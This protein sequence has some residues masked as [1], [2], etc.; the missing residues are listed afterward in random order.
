MG[1]LDTAERFN[2]EGVCVLLLEQSEHTLEILLQM[3]YG[4]GARNCHKC[5]TIGEAKYVAERHTLDLVVLDP[6]L[7]EGDGLDFLRWLR[8]S[9][10]LANRSTPVLVASANG[11]V[12]SVR[13]ARDAG[14]NF[15]IVKP[16]TPAVLMDRIV[17]VTRD[18]RSF[19]VSDVYQGPDR[20]FKMEG[21]PPGL[22]PRRSTDITTRLGD[23]TEPN[24][25]QDDINSLFKPQK[26]ML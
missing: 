23:A 13:G 8:A 19:V 18:R 5:T 3:F 26:V 17:R 15:F 7:K 2:F 11:T 16:M 14:A 12:S 1:T 25:S 21:P 4:F 6:N 22:P 20:R 10:A 9:E 24:L